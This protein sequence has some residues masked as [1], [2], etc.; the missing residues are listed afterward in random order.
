M[1]GYPNNSLTNQLHFLPKR[2][3]HGVLS[4]LAVPVNPGN[5]AP[6]AEELRRAGYT[7]TRGH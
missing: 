7:V 6:L 5:G 1:A 3:M 4:P 2:L